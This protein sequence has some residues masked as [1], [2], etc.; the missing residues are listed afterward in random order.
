MHAYIIENETTCDAVI[1]GVAATVLYIAPG[2]RI[3]LPACMRSDIL[4]SLALLMLESADVRPRDPV[5]LTVFSTAA[6]GAG[7]LRDVPDAMLDR[8]LGSVI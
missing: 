2:A 3:A 8:Y 1:C 5:E 7:T 4:P 6:P